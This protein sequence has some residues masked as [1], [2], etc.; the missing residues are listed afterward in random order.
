[1]EFVHPTFTNL[2]LNVS[3]FCFLFVL[4]KKCLFCDKFFA[5]HSLKYVTMSAI[6]LTIIN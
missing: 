1:M 3:V 5:N 2:S 6:Y 4:T